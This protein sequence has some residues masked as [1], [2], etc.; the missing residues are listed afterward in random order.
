MFAQ[1][2]LPAII[3][4]DQVWTVS[5]SPYIISQN[6][7]V[8]TGVSITIQPG[9]HVKS[10]GTGLQLI[11]DGELQ[12]LGTKDSLIKFDTITIKT[13]PKTI[14]YDVVSGNGF[15][16]NYCEF[17]GS[18][19]GTVLSLLY[20]D[21]K[22]TNSTFAQ[23]GTAIRFSPSN[24][25]GNTLEVRGCHFDNILG[26][27][28]GYPLYATGTKGTSIVTNNTFLNSYTIYVYGDITF[29]EN[30]VYN[31][32]SIAISSYNSKECRIKCNNIRKLNYDMDIN[33]SGDTTKVLFLNNT[34]D[35]VGYK[36]T[37]YNMLNVSK[38]G[39][40]SSLL[41]SKFNNNNFL[42]SKNPTKI[43]IKGNNTVLT[44]F[45][46][47]DFKD[48]YWG[49]TD[50]SII[51]GQIRDYNDNITIYAKADFSNFDSSMK[52]NCLENKNNCV[53]D[54]THTTEKST[55]T[56]KSTSPDR[57]TK[58][59]IQGAGTKYGANVSNTFADS[60]S[61]KVCMF[62]LNE[63]STIC[64]SVCKTIVINDYC[65]AYYT[66]AVDSSISRT[67]FIINS[68]R[69]TSGSTSFYWSFGDGYWSDLKKPKHTYYVSG[70]Y[71]LCLTIFDSVTN[72]TS[73]YC[74]SIGMDSNGNVYRSGA[75]TIN[76]LDEKD[77][78]S[79]T[80]DLVTFKDLKAY[81]NPSKG[82]ITLQHDIIGNEEV[83]W[84]IYDM[85]GTKQLLNNE[86]QQNQDKVSLDLS[87]LPNGVYIISAECQGV[88][89]NIKV[90]V[91]K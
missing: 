28:F 42:N 81:P 43:L 46:T 30:E 77:F 78:N 2:T 82:R 27:G 11:L 63:D 31:I 8:D 65:E 64:D 34:L 44:T 51:A 53:A 60:G 67:L 37:N 15:R 79:S 23:F 61:Y 19:N 14:G 70:K 84:T 62:I 71:E 17:V 39:T 83:S 54:F 40:N 6:T 80:V 16:L 76:V 90:I 49:T 13:S 9:V 35:S 36:Y 75:F 24:T 74:D 18:G 12:A 5:G 73:T 85:V 86:P 59:T 48:N 68:S 69:Y 10:L 50:S 89:K 41:G 7:Y 33:V 72:C 3:S 22:I 4:S 88:T 1:T 45:E 20:T 91:Q 55:S 52:P 32:N 66:V 87:E 21:V 56:F 26:N 29:E 47:L 25:S 57:I 58:W 38:L